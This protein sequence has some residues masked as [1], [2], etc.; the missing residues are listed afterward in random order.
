MKKKTKLEVLIAGGNKKT[1]F[2]INALLNKGHFVTLVHDD[3]DFC[4]A[5]VRKYD[6]N[7]ING[8]GSKPY[9]LEDAEVQ[10]KDMVIAMTP[11]DPSNLVICQLSK[12]VYGVRKAFST[13]NNPKNVEVFK[14]LG[15]DMAISATYVIT[16]II[17][18]IVTIEEISNFMPIGNGELVIF[19]AVVSESSPI[20]GKYLSEAM[21]PSDAVIGC[22]LRGSEMIV[23]R[24]NTKVFPDDK[25]VIIALAEV[26]AEVLDKVVGK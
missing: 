6:I 10:E 5:M 17:E 11:K 16:K 24:G 13:V 25:L 4:R 3:E 19:E 22:V 1:D 8:D 23:P 20:Q 14:S 9:I 7:V 12:K 26:K 2:L 21:I 18:Q 15:V